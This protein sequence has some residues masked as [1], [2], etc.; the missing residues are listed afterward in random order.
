MSIGLDE[1]LDR[2]L[3]CASV[4][5]P[6]EMDRGLMHAYI[7]CLSFDE[8]CEAICRTIE[9]GSVLRLALR[10]RLLRLLRLSDGE[11]ADRLV[12]LAQQA[13]SLHNDN[14]VLRTRVDALLSAIY[15]WLPITARHE[16]L[17][18]WVDRGTSGTAA[19]WMK[20]LGSD[21][22]LFD[23]A[24]LFAYWQQ[25]HD[26]RAAKLLAYKAEATFL[27]GILPELARHCDEG[28]VIS[29]AA[30]RAST[31]PDSV[32]ESLRGAHPASYAYLCAMTGRKITDDEAMALIDD[33]PVGVIDDGRGLV[34]WSIGQMG[35]ITVLDRLRA[36]REIYAAEEL[37]AILGSRVMGD[38]AEPAGL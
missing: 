25:T 3:D 6:Y 30:L 11:H 16:V 29:K 33:A 35:M 18:D 23:P 2:I 1:K 15:S 9:E 28:W 7:A 10:S 37:A 14:S 13:K 27:D 21:D 22:A 32:W 36:D 38:P 17:E 34:I 5:S 31:I 12:E 8:L 26:Y 19:R 24:A 4:S 20:A